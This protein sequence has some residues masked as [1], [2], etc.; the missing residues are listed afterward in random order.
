PL[1]APWGVAI[2]PAGF[3]EFAGDIL[4]GNFGDGR[5]NVFDKHGDFIDQL[6]GAE[7]KAITIDGLWS[8][9]FGGGLNSSPD[10]LYFSAGPNNSADGIFGMIQAQ[11]AADRDDADDDHDRDHEHG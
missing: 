10:T 5:I 8:L 2:A 6:E 1:D 7:G 4:V 9:T 11:P 3:G